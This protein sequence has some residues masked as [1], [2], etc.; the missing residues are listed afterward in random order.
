[1]LE[2]LQD[3][4]Y[5]RAKE[6]KDARFN[7]LHDKIY[8]MDVLQEAW[9]LVWENRGSEGVDN[10][11]L[12]D[13]REEGIEQLLE[14]IQHEL[15]TGT[16]RAS[17]VRRVFI[18]KSSGKL[19][20]LG[21]PTVKDRIVQQAVKLIIEPIFEADFL[22]FSYGYRPNRSAKDA[23]LEIYKWLNYGLTNIV[24]VDIEGFFDHID[25]ELLLKFVKE[26]VTDGYILS[27]IKQ[28]LKAGIVYGKSVTNPTE[29]TPQG[30]SFLR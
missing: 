24:D 4:L 29:G 22:E 11:T 3:G 25:H 20:P 30:V 7:T 17:C 26:R 8:R 23:S 27:L 19:R 6:N 13:I 12:D 1:M 15:K 14:Q 9:R 10:Q 16:Y 5:R 28:W 18:P 21:I 2:G